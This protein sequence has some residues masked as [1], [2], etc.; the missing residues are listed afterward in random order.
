MEFDKEHDKENNRKKAVDEK[1]D[2]EIEKAR[3]EILK[4]L[5]RI[6]ENQPVPTWSS[7]TTRYYYKELGFT[8]SEM[9]DIMIRILDDR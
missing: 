3:M 9:D 1:R 8:E 4:Q 7:E 6:M 5:D 2:L